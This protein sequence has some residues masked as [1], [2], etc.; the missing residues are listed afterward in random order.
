[1]TFKSIINN[2]RAMAQA[3]REI[4]AE[5]TVWREAGS[6]YEYIRDCSESS[7]RWNIGEAPAHMEDEEFMRRV[8][9][10]TVQL[11]QIH[12]FGTDIYSYLHEA[13][14]EDTKEIAALSE[15][16]LSHQNIKGLRAVFVRIVD[17][18]PEVTV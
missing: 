15:E 11:L 3:H 14:V 10:A 6:A 4:K 7:V 12:T 17:P 2:G 18:I 16:R 9:D 8:G 5:R 1:M 13:S